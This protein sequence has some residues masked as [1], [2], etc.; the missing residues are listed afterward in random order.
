MSATNYAPRERHSPRRTWNRET[1][2]AALR[3]WWETMGSAPRLNDWTA[4]KYGQH[5]SAAQ[6]RWAAE[7]PRWPSPA[8]V[9]GYFGGWNEALEAAGVPVTHSLPS[10]DELAARVAEAKRLDGP[11]LNGKEIAK[12]LDVHPDTARRY[13]RAG[14]CSCGGPVLGS[15]STPPVCARCAPTKAPHWT[16]AQVIGCYQAWEAET[17]AAPTWVDWQPLR[18]RGR[19]WFDEFPRWPSAGEAVAPFGTW[20]DLQRA[21]GRAPS[22]FHGRW[23]HETALAALRACTEELGHAPTSRELTGRLDVPG[24]ATLAELFGTLRQAVF[25]ATGAI[26]NRPRAWSRDEILEA[27]RRLAAELGRR[28]QC[29]DVIGRADMPSNG[30]ITRVFGHFSVAVAEAVGEP[31]PVPRVLRR[32]SHDDLVAALRDLAQELGRRPRQRDVAGREDM[33][34]A[35]TCATQ[36][37]TFTAAVDAAYT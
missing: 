13:V 15:K 29:R 5:R 24:A 2:I 30:A 34:S 12:L 31:V 23:T 26:G 22:R 7:F 19:K 14:V 9:T 11:G 28:P 16:Q 10:V 18:T 6:L 37:G 33:P 1:V 36:F 3:D 27:L 17:G 35:H 8:T 20:A 21:A 32:W 25:E 4:P